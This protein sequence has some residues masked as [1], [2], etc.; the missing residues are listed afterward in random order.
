MN[1]PEFL[2]D[3]PDAEIRLTGHRISLYDVFS[4]H[5]ILIATA[6]LPATPFFQ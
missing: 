5:S 6:S 3:D 1:L 2:I 4:L